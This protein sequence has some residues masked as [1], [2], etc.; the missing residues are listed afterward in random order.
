MTGYKIKGQQKSEKSWNSTNRPFLV[1]LT[2]LFAKD[3]LRQ[4]REEV[5]YTLHEL[6][7]LSTTQSTA[8]KHNLVFIAARSK[9][10]MVEGNVCLA[11]NVP[12]HSAISRILTQDLGY[13]FKKVSAVLQGSLTPDAEARLIQYLPVCMEIDPRTMHFFDECSVVKTSGN[14][15]YRNS[16]VGQPALEVQRYPS[17]ATF[18][19]NLL[20][21]MYGVGQVNLLPG[22][23]NGL[24]L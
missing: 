8:S 24:E 5:K 2:T 23:S 10:K 1:L 6:M 22:P 15:H 17:N 13:S 7:M 20:H 9:G 16:L 11:Q 14:R 18:T 12:S 3:M 21:D 19:V 4:E